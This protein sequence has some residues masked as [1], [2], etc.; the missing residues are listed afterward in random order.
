MGYQHGVVHIHPLVAAFA[1]RSAAPNSMA[2]TMS[3]LLDHAAA[4]LPTTPARGPDPLRAIEAADE[5]VVLSGHMQRYEVTL[6][7]ARDVFGQAADH[8]SA[9]W[10]HDDAVTLNRHLIAAYGQTNERTLRLASTSGP[11]RS[12]RRPR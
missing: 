7:R 8:L 3:Y 10:A 11:G 6:E 2:Q 9:W 1:R 4:H 5:I 12:T